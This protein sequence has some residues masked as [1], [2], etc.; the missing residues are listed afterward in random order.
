MEQPP[1]PDAYPVPPPAPKK[2]RTGWYVAGALGLLIVGAAIGQSDTDPGT[3]TAP[4][5]SDVT[6]DPVGLPEEPP[7]DDLFSDQEACNLINEALLSDEASSLTPDE[8]YEL[9]QEAY[10]VAE[11]NGDVEDAVL[12]AIFAVDTN[13]GPAASQAGEDLAFACAE[14]LFLD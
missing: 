2:R 9:L 11:P 10:A 8:Q 13:D 5:A 14:E 3:T 6:D 1:R 7:A 4:L 12:D